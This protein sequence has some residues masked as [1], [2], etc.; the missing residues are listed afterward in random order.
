ME[1]KAGGVKGLLTDL[2]LFNLGSIAYGIAVSMFTAPNDIAPGGVTGIATVINYISRQTLPVG[3]PIGML[4]LV[5]NLPLL[6]A[7]WLR[8]GSRMAGR[9]LLCILFS[10][11]WTDVLGSVLPP[12]RGEMILTCI[13]GGALMGLG[14]G[15]IL[16]RGG[17]TGG[18]EIVARLLERRWPHIP[19][20]RL[21]LMVDGLIIALSA[22]VYRQLES[23][24]YAVV[25]VFI[26]SQV[27]DWLVYG[28]RRGKMA[29]ILSKKQPMLVERIVHELDRGAT[30]LRAVGAYTGKE[31]N[32]ILCAVSREEIYP[33]KRLVFKEDPEA[34]FMVLSTDEVLGL[35]WQD[36]GKS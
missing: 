23:P 1:K 29:M 35:G 19:I 25:L 22:L 36:P 30:L 3:L 14:I 17:T 20:G 24:L 11:V 9:T 8:F 6:A 4:T 26:S 21:M 32:M 27:T 16:S 5:M 28:G 10:S 13:F 31:Q 7:A 2:L 12:F 33:L 15:L 18:T 34:F